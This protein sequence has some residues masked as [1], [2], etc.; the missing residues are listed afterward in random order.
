MNNSGGAL[1]FDASI[2]DINFRSQL[3]AMERRIMGQLS[4]EELSVNKHDK[5]QEN[6][7]KRGLIY[8]IELFNALGF[9]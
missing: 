1:S 9:H 7:L 6:T 5:N 8:L 3:D 2:N 4:D